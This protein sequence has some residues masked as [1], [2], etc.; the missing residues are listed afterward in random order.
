MRAHQVE[1]DQPELGLARLGLELLVVLEV[2]LKRHR[3]HGSGV[4]QIVEDEVPHLT[5]RLEVEGL[6]QEPVEGLG[7]RAEPVADLVAV[8]PRVREETRLRDL[9]RR[10]PELA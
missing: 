10:A 4:Q 7:Q 1:L 6:H 8:R 9:A 2:G 3:V 5:E